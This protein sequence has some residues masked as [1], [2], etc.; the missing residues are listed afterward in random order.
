MV[1]LSDV[2]GHENPSQAC[3]WPIAF[4]R[5]PGALDVKERTTECIVFRRTQRV[6]KSQRTRIGRLIA[7]CV[8]KEDGNMIN[9]LSPEVTFIPN[10]VTRVE[11]NFM[12]TD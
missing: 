5:K 2:C 4:P 10:L 8:L 3:G 1:Q 7:V 12:R 11:E 6:S 9:L